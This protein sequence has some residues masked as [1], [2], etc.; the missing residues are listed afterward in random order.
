MKKITAIFLITLYS[1]TTLGIGIRQFY[2]CGKLKSTNITLVQEAKEKCSNSDAMKGCCKTQFKSLKVKDS[3]VAADG[4]AVLVKH[5][6]DLHIATPAF[7]VKAPVNEPV[8]VANASNA[9]PPKLNGIAIYIL[10]CTY[11][12]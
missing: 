6:T 11:R 5:F 12:I 7:E 4:I 10:N 3:H 1:L 8:V 9:P 2:C